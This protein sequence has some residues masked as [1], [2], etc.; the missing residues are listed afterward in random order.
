[1][2]RM[3]LVLGVAIISLVAGCA[4]T[5]QLR[6]PVVE[7]SSATKAVST[8]T[9][10]AFALADAAYRD[11]QSAAKLNNYLNKKNFNLEYKPLITPA[12]MNSRRDALRALEKYADRL[13]EIVSE[14]QLQDLDESS[15]KF[16]DSLRNFKAI[17]M[18]SADKTVLAVGE[19]AVRAIGEFIIDRQRAIAVKDAVT[20]MH[21]NLER[22]ATMLIADIGEPQASVSLRT[23]LRADYELAQAA[24]EGI[25]IRLR[26]DQKIS[27]EKQTEWF[28]KFS[29][30]SSEYQKWD[31]T[32]ASVQ[33]ALKAM[34]TAHSSLLT[35]SKDNNTARA[36]IQNFIARI[37]TIVEFYQYAA[38]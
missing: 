10:A 22:I 6:E 29:A 5:S 20:A 25:L 12:G 32:L 30:K 18:L 33:D 11:T 35:I 38:R 15:R 36:E 8:S 21:P 9:I 14:K 34:V 19:T 2:K 24:R 27:G 1:M 26:D 16:S 13:G 37:Q 7:F 31:S 3:R 4:G 23:Q 28:E 17:D